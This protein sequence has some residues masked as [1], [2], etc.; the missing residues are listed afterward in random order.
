M[1]FCAIVLMGVSSVVTPWIAVV[2]LLAP[3]IVGGLNVAGFSLI[4]WAYLAVAAVPFA[5][6]TSVHSVL[7]F[8]FAVGTLDR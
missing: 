7:I 2:V 1:L 6:M 8:L 4:Y 5:L 3:V